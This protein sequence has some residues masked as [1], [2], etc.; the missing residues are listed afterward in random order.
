MIN[1]DQINSVN[2]FKNFRMHSHKIQG[3]SIGNGLSNPGDHLRK[4]MAMIEEECGMRFKV[5]K[6]LGE[7]TY[8]VVYQALDFTTNKVST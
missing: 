5:Y 6:V 4:N 8:G 3:P 7:G 2:L 1:F